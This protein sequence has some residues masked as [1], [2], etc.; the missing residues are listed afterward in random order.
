MYVLQIISETWKFLI[1]ECLN[2]GNTKPKVQHSVTAIYFTLIS[3]LFTKLYTSFKAL[4]IKTKNKV[5]DKF[6]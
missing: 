4:N 6:L 3:K 2:I 5:F 1:E